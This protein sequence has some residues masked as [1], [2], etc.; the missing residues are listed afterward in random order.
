VADRLSA[1]TVQA[2]ASAWR[3]SDVGKPWFTDM[4]TP[5]YKA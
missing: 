3:R 1:A 4:L 5:L 2:A